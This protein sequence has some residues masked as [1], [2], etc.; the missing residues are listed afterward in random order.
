M[1]TAALSFLPVSFRRLTFLLWK[2]T[3]F[4]FKPF[5]IFLWCFLQNLT[6][7]CRGLSSSFQ[8]DEPPCA[9]WT[10]PGLYCVGKACNVLFLAPDPMLGSHLDTK[11][12]LFGLCPLWS[13]S[14]HHS[15]RHPWIIKLQVSPATV[16]DRHF[17]QN[18]SAV[19]VAFCSLLTLCSVQP[20]AHTWVWTGSWMKSLLEPGISHAIHL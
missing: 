20:K 4:I 18:T 8:I 2:S 9:P 16:Q 6:A 7:F 11:C 15:F 19:I 13:P 14:V 10:V 5:R 3:V 1:A 17:Q 12:A